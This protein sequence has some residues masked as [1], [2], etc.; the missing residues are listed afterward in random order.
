MSSSPEVHDGVTTSPLQG[1]ASCHTLSQC[2]YRVSSSSPP[3]GGGGVISLFAPFG[4]G[5]GHGPDAEATS[6][7]QEGNGSD[8]S[9]VLCLQRG[10]STS[11]LPAHSSLLCV[12]P[13]LSPLLFLKSRERK[14][15]R[16]SYSVSLSI[17]E[18]SRG[19]SVC[20]CVC[21][22]LSLSLSLFQSIFLSIS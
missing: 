1:W 20:V 11:A 9:H 6:L 4:L 18:W 10:C 19:E 16:R 8:Y 14:W 12:C 7:S 3:R 13:P 21:A 2:D 22:P 15:G 17:R 5:R